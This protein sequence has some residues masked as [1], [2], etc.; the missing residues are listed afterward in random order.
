MQIKTTILLV[1]L[2][3][4]SLTACTQS[5][6]STSNTGSATT[7]AEQSTLSTP[8]RPAEINGTV[9]NITGNEIIIAN[10]VGKIQLSEEEQAAKKEEMQNLSPEERQALRETE[11]AD[12]DTEDMTLTIP[13]GIDILKGSGDGSGNNIAAEMTEIKSGTYISIWTSGDEVEIIKIKGAN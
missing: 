4:L 2:L 6:D 3:T 7:G 5:S 8:T 13:V 1:T 10:E 12:I 11:K 9:K